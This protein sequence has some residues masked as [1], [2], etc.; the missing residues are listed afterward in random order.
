LRARFEKQA[1]EEVRLTREQ[2]EEL[3]KMLP[4]ER[5]CFDE[6]MSR[7]SFVGMGGPA[8]AF[9]IAAD[10]VELRELIAWAGERKVDY[11]FVGCGGKTIVRDGGIRGLTIRL[12]EGFRFINVESESDGT[13]FVSVGSSTTVPEFINWCADNCFAGLEE[14]VSSCGS[15]GGC[16]SMNVKVGERSIGD[17]VEEI[18]IINREGKELSLRG[19]S[20]RFDEDSLKIPRTAVIAR[21][22]FRLGRGDRSEI[23][24]K[25]EGF[26]ESLSKKISQGIGFI[27]GVFKS[28]GKTSADILIDDARLNG[29]RVGGA[30]VSMIDSNAIVNEGKATARNVT[31]LMSLIR[32]RVKQQTGIVLEPRISIIGKKENT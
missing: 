32:D 3:S 21:A 11:C 1:E 5:V 6:C 7:H 26:N 23:M 29:I 24:A 25:L 28:E 20:L 10:V 30:R 16:L 13:V 17:F 18:T 27:S 8:E 9:S 22:V 12:G 15:I 31:V 14:L 19:K 4:P 2:R